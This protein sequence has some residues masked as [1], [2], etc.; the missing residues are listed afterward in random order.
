MSIVLLEALACGLP[1]IVTDVGENAVVIENGVQ[2][3]VIPPN[4]TGELTKALDTLLNNPS[5]RETMRAN[6]LERAKDFSDH[7]M[8]ETLQH[9]Y[10]EILGE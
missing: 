2:G 8:I 6:A 7:K 3:L 5:L 1:C 4:Q 9:L 10:K